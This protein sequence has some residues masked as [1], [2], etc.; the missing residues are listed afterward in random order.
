MTPTVVERLEILRRVAESAQRTAVR[1][2]D[3]QYT[4]VFQHW[5]NEL[6]L[7]KKD[8]TPE[9]KLGPFAGMTAAQ[10][11]GDRGELG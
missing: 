4:D 9:V 6:A 7:L 3:S 10:I 8:L 1:R 2:A 5:L 11:A